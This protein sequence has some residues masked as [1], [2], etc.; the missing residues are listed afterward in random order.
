VRLAR[1]IRRRL[2]RG[3]AAVARNLQRQAGPPVYVL[4]SHHHLARPAAIARLLGRTSARFVCLVHDLI[5]VAYA[6]YAR[7]GQPEVHA[8]RMR[9]AAQL[10]DGLILNSSATARDLAPF[11]AEAGR[12]PGQCVAALGVDLPAMPASEPGDSAS[13]IC[14]STI[15]PRK[16]HLLLLNLWR[17]LAAALGPVTPRLVLVGRRGWENEN[18]IDM[19]ERCQPIRGFVE[20]HNVLADGE[21]ARRLGAARALLLPSFAEGYGLPVAEALAAGVPVIC[22]D[23][24]ALRE[25]GGDVPEYLDPLDGPA[26][27]TA[28]LDYA[29]PDSP[30]RAAQLVRL[31]NWQAPRWSNHFGAVETLLANLGASVES[32]AGTRPHRENRA[33]A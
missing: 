4:V 27:R 6:E 5:P 2:L 13:F 8:R 20:E 23:L 33:G 29:R 16:N 28:I 18:V 30:R 11:L 24:P 9:T 1:R 17:A 3:E 19:I 12:Q 22:S 32:N 25:V 10:A 7:P 26:W 31:R 21:L 14:I 15:E